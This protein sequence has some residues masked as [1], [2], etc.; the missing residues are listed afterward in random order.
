MMYISCLRVS[1]WL[2]IIRLKIWSSIEISMPCISQQKDL[3]WQQWIVPKYCFLSSAYY[4]LYCTGLKLSTGNFKTILSKSKINSMPLSFH[5]FLVRSNFTEV[6]LFPT[7]FSYKI[8]FT[9][10][11]GAWFWIT[12]PL[13]ASVQGWLSPVTGQDLVNGI[14]FFS[15]VQFWHFW[16]MQECTESVF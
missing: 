13:W 15:W 9:H 8:F 1:V 7:F 10:Y 12:S 5:L 2:S 16:G 4:P 3:N 11:T 14:H 6:H